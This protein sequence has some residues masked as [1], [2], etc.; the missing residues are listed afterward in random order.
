MANAKYIEYKAAGLCVRC[1]NTRLEGKTRCI[2]CHQQHLA[3]NAK[4]KS[5][6]MLKG[7][8]RYCLIRP[9][10]PGKSMCGGCLVKH[11]IK[12]KTNYQ[13]YRNAAIIAY[14]ECCVC[15]GNPNQKYLQLDHI[16]NDGVTHRAEVF[17]NRRTG[18]MYKW[19][20]INNFPNNLQ[21]LCANCHQAKTVYGG[22]DEHDHPPYV[23]PTCSVQFS[24]ASNG[25]QFE[26]GPCVHTS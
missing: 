22:C 20:T 12:Q 21:L 4:A 6:A 16:H 26:H 8:C 15:C 1:G 7:D 10:E 19:A 13:K 17:N 14:G 24:D 3:Y 9:I 2:D 18:N 25:Y 5:K 11:N 23:R